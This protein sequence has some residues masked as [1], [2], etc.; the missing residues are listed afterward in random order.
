MDKTVRFNIST[1][2]ITMYADFGKCHKPIL[3]VDR[4]A[5]CEVLLFILSGCM[6]VVEEGTEYFLQAGDVFFLK[7]G[8]HHWGQTPFSPGTSWYFVHF[9]H[10][11]VNP[12][13]PEISPEFFHEKH[14]DCTAE[15]F[16]RI[17]TLPKHLHNM[18]NTDLQ[19]K[20]EKMTELFNSNNPYLIA[21]LNPCLHEL[22]VDIYMESLR[23]PD[24]RNSD[25]RIHNVFTYFTLHINEPFNSKGLSDY[26]GL[27]YRYLSDI[28]SKKTGMTLHEC[29]TRIKMEKACKML[30][31][32]RNTISEI[33]EQLGYSDPLYFSN[34]FKKNTG[35]SPRTYRQ[36]YT[37]K[38]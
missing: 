21:Y 10:D 29:H 1:M 7:Q 23:S 18:L 27:N 12:D 11:D 4:T 34:V 14:V 32:E 36:K 31:Q 15:D 6:P 2:P 24:P 19:A 13:T 9:T 30:C 16:N 22:L 5:H 35:M 38:L 26:L 8:V 17:I 33:S 28:F 20:F 37:S 3:H 25:T